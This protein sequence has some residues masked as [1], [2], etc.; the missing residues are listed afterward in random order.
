M[1]SKSA[2][3]AL[4]SFVAFCFFQPC[5][6][7]KNV[8]A[9]QYGQFPV[10]IYEGPIRIPTYV[11][12]VS[13]GEWRDENYKLVEPPEVNFAGEYYLSAHS[14]GTSCRYYQL[15]NLRTGSEVDQISMFNAGEPLP[16]TKDRHDYL[17]ILLHRPD[18]KLLIVQ[19]LIDP[20]KTADKSHCRQRYFVFDGGRITAI[21]KTFLSCTREDGESK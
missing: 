17:P 11:S 16:Q 19:Y 5:V 13:D 4:L 6:A 1:T 10:K 20:I 21:S 12:K 14:C 8:D 9:V 7:Q 2:H 18:S 15:T 3:C